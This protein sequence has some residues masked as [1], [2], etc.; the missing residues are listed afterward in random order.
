MKKVKKNSL[1]INTSVGII[2]CGWLGTALAQCLL[3][4][5]IEVCATVTSI[6]KQKALKNLAINS[7][8]VQLPASVNELKNKHV[9]KQAQLVICI[10]PQ[11]RYGKKD[12][13]LKIKNIVSAANNSQVKHIILIST[14]A[15]YG[16]LTGNISEDAILD[17]NNEKVQALVNAE[18]ALDAFLGA[19]TILRLT[20]LV[21]EDRHPGRFLAG[22]TALSN[23]NAAVNIIHQE[24]AVG[25]IRCLLCANTLNSNNTRSNNIEIFNGSS[26][27]HVS[28]KE[29]YQKAAT[30][31]NLTPAEFLTD[32]STTDSKII[33]AK[34][35]Q[36]KHNYQFVYPDLCAW[37]AK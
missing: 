27:T 37:L 34:K 7:E 36:D 28:R 13:A 33:L 10:T 30:A 23:A 32:L 5:N 31:I 15:V 4:D 26:N 6:K 1:N 8:R 2:G 22:K 19:K 29:F 16:N 24:D 21:G 11:L 14:S 12:Y 20:G 35:I 9:F 17:L 18:Q 25:I 3:K